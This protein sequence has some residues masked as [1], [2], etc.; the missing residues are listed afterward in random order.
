MLINTAHLQHNV[1][2]LLHLARPQKIFPVIKANAYGHGLQLIA[3]TLERQFSEIDLPYFCVARLS[4][5]RALR[6][7]GIKRR[8]LVINY[9]SRD[10]FLDPVTIPDAVDLAVHD[11]VDLETIHSVAS[12]HALKDWGVHINFNTGMNRLG[13]AAELSDADLVRLLEAVARLKQ[14]KIATSGLMTH[15][16]RGEEDPV[17]YSA[18]QVTLFERVVTR[19]KSRWDTS[20]HGPFPKWVHAENSGALGQRV[21]ENK[22]F[23]TAARPGIHV[24]GV[25]AA[26][27]AFQKLGLRPVMSVRAP[28]RQLFWVPQGESIGYGSFYRCTRNTLV[29]TVPLGYADGVPRFFSRSE[30]ETSSAV[31]FIIDGARVQILG[32]VSMDLTCVDMTDHP[33]ARAWAEGVQQARRPEIWANWIGEGQSVHEIAREMNTIEYEILC[34]VASR[35]SRR[36]V[37]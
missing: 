16:A 27:V 34:L 19:I 10:D 25:E 18:A 15:L 7:A 23:L 36:E 3:G 6:A 30:K 31:G 8:F 21:G 9:F 4:E 35:L 22:D 17:L 32:R 29:G 20:I 12:Q 1:K 5:A 24:W 2:T 11:F 28:V 14:K 37:Q 13:F 33:Q 26:P